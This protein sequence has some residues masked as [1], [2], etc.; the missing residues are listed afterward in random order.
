MRPTG[1]PGQG[2]PMRSLPR[3]LGRALALLLLAP[4]PVVAP[5]LAPT[6]APPS[7]EAAMVPAAR[8]ATPIS[9]AT[10][11]ATQNGSTATVRGYVV[12]QPT[13]STTVVT[14]GFPNDYALALADTAG[15][16]NTGQ[17]LYVQIPSAFR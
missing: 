17:M 9:V 5:A 2:P 12:G 15:T 7:L 16:T 3:A 6:L 4:L 1:R 11:R 13:S 10:A 14:S 8:A